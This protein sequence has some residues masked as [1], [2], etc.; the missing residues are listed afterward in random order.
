L[1]NRTEPEPTGIVLVSLHGDTTTA[2][3]ASRGLLQGKRR[4]PLLF[5]QSVPSSILGYVSAK[6]G[7]TGP[8]ITVSA[9]DGALD[10][11][12]RLASFM[13]A[14]VRSVLLLSV[15]VPAT[16][17]SQALYR[18]LGYELPDGAP[19]AYG[20]GLA[21]AAA[22]RDEPVAMGDTPKPPAQPVIVRDPSGVRIEPPRHG[23][24]RELLE[25]EPFAILPPDLRGYAGV[26]A[27]CDPRESLTTSHREASPA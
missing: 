11:G 12:L 1:T 4:N 26:W 9:G 20:F 15:A 16:A 14:S 25:A 22:E 3:L 23:S 2:D 13:L 17:R 19:P 6:Y 27:L 18:G 7:I 24:L 8:M 5:Y 21:L 10:E